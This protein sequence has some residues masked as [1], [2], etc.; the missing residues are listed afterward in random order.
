LDIGYRF[1]LAVDSG[2]PG[3][4]VNPGTTLRVECEALDSLVAD[5]S[6]ISFYFLVEKM[7]TCVYV[8]IIVNTISI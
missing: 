2:L 8:Y 6:I 1:D 3:K 7:C 4:E 5:A